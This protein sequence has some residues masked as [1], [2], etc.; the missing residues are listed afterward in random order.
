VSNPRNI[1]QIGYYRPNDATTWAAYFHKGFVFVADNTRGVDI[2][3]FNAAG[4]GRS[5]SVLAPALRRAPEAATK[6]RFRPSPTYG[7]LCRIPKSLG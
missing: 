6:L 3:R 4:R 7:W 1:R 5:K 2:L